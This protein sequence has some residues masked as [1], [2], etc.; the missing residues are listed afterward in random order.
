MP[1]ELELRT[2]LLRAVSGHVNSTLPQHCKNVVLSVSELGLAAESDERLSIEERSALVKAID[3]FVEKVLGYVLS[4]QISCEG[5]FPLC[6]IKSKTCDAGRWGFNFKMS[7]NGAA[8]FSVVLKGGD[9]ERIH[10]LMQLSWVLSN[11]CES[12]F[13]HSFSGWGSN[14]MDLIKR[15]DTDTQVELIACQ[16]LVE[17]FKRLDTLI[18]VQGVKKTASPLASKLLQSMTKKMS[19]QGVDAGT[20]VMYGKVTVSVVQSLASQT[21]HLDPAMEVIVS[22]LVSGEATDAQ[23]LL[24]SEFLG[25]VLTSTKDRRQWS[26][27]VR[28]LLSIAN[29]VLDQILGD[30]E[31]DVGKE[32]SEGS[33]E[34]VEGAGALPGAIKCLA[35]VEI[36]GQNSAPAF[37]IFAGIW[38]ALE[39]VLALPISGSLPIP[40][41]HV[42]A[43]VSRLLAVDLTSA[44]RRFKTTPNSLELFGRLTAFHVASWEMLGLLCRVTR[45]QM[46]PM[47][48][49]VAGLLKELLHRLAV[50]SSEGRMDMEASA[51]VSMYGAAKMVIQLAGFPFID[52]LAADVITCFQ[53]EHSQ[54]LGNS[55]TRDDGAS[56]GVSK[57]GKKRKSSNATESDL[58]AADVELAI[59]R[60]K[61]LSNGAGV[62]GRPQRLDD[63][64]GQAQEKAV[65]LVEALF[66]VGGAVMKNQIR[67]AAEKA[68]SRVVLVM[69]GRGSMSIPVCRALLAAVL[70]PCQGR[71][72]LMPLACRVL[73]E[74]RHHP[75]PNFRS[76]VCEASDRLEAILHPR[77]VS[78]HPEEVAAEGDQGTTDAM[79]Y[80][81]IP[82][83]LSAGVSAEPGSSQGLLV[84]QQKKQKQNA[85]DAQESM[86]VEQGVFSGGAGI[87]NQPS[88]GLPP[89]GH[90][91]PEDGNKSNTHVRPVISS[92]NLEGTTGLSSAGASLSL[93]P[94]GSAQGSSLRS[95][96]AQKTDVPTAGPPPG[97][98]DFWEVQPVHGGVVSSDDD[99]QLSLDKVAKV[100]NEVTENFRAAKR[101]DSEES[102]SEGPLPD[103]DSG[104]SEED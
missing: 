76:F 60:S 40:T 80:L 70:S 77:A 93:K 46:L 63:P 104:M 83:R 100:P 61:P 12:R 102:D 4:K 30:W 62:S 21:Q 8:M 15:K 71:S 65:E 2:N 90:S 54:L 99:L 22:K 87:E 88:M 47:C 13:V 17:L 6:Q 64:S 58:L 48:G 36:S 85:T 49:A 81:A 72:R 11:C 16:L 26:A 18:W 14:L 31:L 24:A 73:N 3:V 52:R 98:G 53:L 89:M 5:V 57:S 92:G 101:G 103:I 79:E 86:D 75:N 1:N 23:R 96:F 43:L 68:I 37:K 74:G 35:H 95:A 32:R 59:A 69:V 84:P 55:V 25:A 42:F 20:F 45:S 51:R 29:L 94:V 19:S 10:G 34:S 78:I 67:Q 27:V 50:R 33:W 28:Q 56:R 9:G 41:H 66:N 91:G 44:K 39:R 7:I 38:D 82:L 97:A